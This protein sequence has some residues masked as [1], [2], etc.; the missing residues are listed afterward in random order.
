MQVSKSRRSFYLQVLVLAARR[1]KLR[2]FG[3][4]RRSSRRPKV[5]ILIWKDRYLSH[6]SRRSGMKPFGSTMR[7]RTYFLPR[8]VRS[9]TT[10]YCELAT[11]QS[12]KVLSENTSSSC[13]TPT[14]TRLCTCSSLVGFI[15]CENLRQSKPAI[16]YLSQT[17]NK[18]KTYPVVERKKRSYSQKSE[19]CPKR[20]I[21]NRA[22]TAQNGRPRNACSALGQNCVR[23]SE[24]SAKVQ[25]R[26]ADHA[27]RPGKLS[28]RSA[29]PQPS[30]P[31]PCRASRETK[32]RGRATYLAY[33]GR[34][35][36]P[37]RETRPTSGRETIDHSINRPTTP[38]DREI[39]RPRPFRHGHNPTVRPIVPTDRPNA[40]VDPKPFLKPNPHNSSPKPAPT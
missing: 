16:K 9:K 18:L 3:R 11:N 40:A 22:Q 38:A 36:R 34:W 27:S 8:H 13:S 35:F 20:S 33:H 24:V 4:A 32:P 12:H 10:S 17:R 14:T 6:A 30:T 37:S 2:K 5:T 29:T 21:E 39:I 25:N 23:P 1:T 19:D 15:N 31:R 28:P 7:P 26:S